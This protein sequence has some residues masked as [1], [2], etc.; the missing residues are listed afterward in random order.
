M[1]TTTPKLGLKKPGYDDFADIKDF[2]DNMDILDDICGDIAKQMYPVGAIYMS[3]NNTSPETLFPGTT[4]VQLKDTFLLAAGDSYSAGTTGGE[5]THT[6]TSGEM[7]S[8]T[9]TGPSHTHSVGAHSH[10]L[11]NHTHS[12][13]ALSGSTSSTGAKTTTLYRTQVAGPQASSADQRVTVLVA[14]N[15]GYPENYT[16]AN[17]HTH[18]V[19]TSASTSGSGGSGSTGNS[20]SFNT[21][22][23]GTGST[24][25]A[26]SGGAHNNMPPYLAVYVWKRTA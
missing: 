26:G 8:H 19:S 14:Y 23:G 7:P 13:P 25:S 4:W 5:A 17:N 1:S 12:I 22:S 2:N 16:T 18:S 24:G 3:V 15:S 21:G 10:S 11:G 9:H 6:L 20:S